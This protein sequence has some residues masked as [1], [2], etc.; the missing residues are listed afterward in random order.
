[1]HRIAR[2]SV[3]ARHA[4]ALGYLS[5]LNNES[6]TLRPLWQMDRTGRLGLDGQLKRASTPR[7]RAETRRPAHANHALARL[8]DQPEIPIFHDVKSRAERTLFRPADD[9][10]KQAAATINEAGWRL[11]RQGKGP[12]P[13]KD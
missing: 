1:M 5:G 12:A 10:H 6:E 8:R 3:E 2:L 9:A 7:A 4:W 11:L 13:Q